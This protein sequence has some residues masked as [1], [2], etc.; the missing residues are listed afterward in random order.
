VKRGA[1]AILFFKVSDDSGSARVEGGV[2]RRARE[3]K[4]LGPKTFRNGRYRFTWR[5]TRKVEHVSFCLTARDGSGNTSG[6]KCAVV[7]V[8]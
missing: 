1:L 4:H 6:K 7:S 2:Y 8:N 3:L 5:A